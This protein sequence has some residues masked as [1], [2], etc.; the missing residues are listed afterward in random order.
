MIWKWP[1]AVVALFLALPAQADPSQFTA[2]T[3]F[4]WC[5]SDKQSADYAKCAI[6]MTGFVDGARLEVEGSHPGSA[7]LSRTFTSADAIAEF[8]RMARTRED[9]LIGPPEVAVRIAL[10]K[11]FPCLKTN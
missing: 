1:L 10:T 11:S 9:F 2:R 6:Y 8:V 3:L 5:T 7:C 4:E